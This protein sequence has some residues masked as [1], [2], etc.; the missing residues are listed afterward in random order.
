MLGDRR[1]GEAR[2][3]MWQQ[4]RG[5]VLGTSVS[6]VRCKG[7]HGRKGRA[8]SLDLGAGSPPR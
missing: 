7:V 4:W 8:P 2:Q 3:E 5:K 1:G 6:Q